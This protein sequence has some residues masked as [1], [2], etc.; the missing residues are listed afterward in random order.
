MKEKLIKPEIEKITTGFQDW[1]E[2]VGNTTP[3]F[4][5]LDG[6]VLVKAESSNTPF[7]DNAG[8]IRIRKCLTYPTC[9]TC[10]EKYECPVLHKK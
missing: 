4:V 3:G 1:M 9:G 8:T 5:F 7:G 2:D 10:K 6:S